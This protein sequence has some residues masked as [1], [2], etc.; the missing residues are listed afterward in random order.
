M[1]SW[2]FRNKG[3]FA[4]VNL[5]TGAD[6]LALAAHYTRDKF[7]LVAHDWGGAAAWGFA[8]AHPERLSHLVI[9]NSPHPYTFWRE[10]LHNPAQRKAS[11]RNMTMGGFFFINL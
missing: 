7:V 3:G 11:E 6:V 1:H 4:Q 8:I 10:L 5:D 9:I 2:S